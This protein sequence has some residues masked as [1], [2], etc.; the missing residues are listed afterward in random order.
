MNRRDVNVRR[1]DYFAGDY[2]DHVSAILDRCV[3]DAIGPETRMLIKPNLL[4]PAKPETAVLTHPSLVR[5]VCRYVLDAG[6]TPLVADSPATGSFDRLLRIGGYQNALT[7]LTVDIRPFADSVPVDIGAP[8]GTIDLTRDAVES[9]VVINLAKLKT[10][11]QMRLTLA[12]KNLFG[13]VVGMRKP[14]WHMRAGVDIDQFARLLVQIHYAI[15][16]AVSMIDGILAMEG[17]GPG[18]GGTPRHLGLLIGGTDAAAVDAVISSAIGLP[19]E[20]LPTHRAAVTLARFPGEPI[21]H[22]EIPPVKSFRLPESGRVIFGPRPIRHMVR[23]WVLHRPVVE[24]DRCRSCGE[25]WT[26]CPAAAVRESETAVDFDYDTCIRCYCCV[27]VCPHG[28]LTARQPA[29]GRILD[30]VR[31]AA[32]RL[33]RRV[34]PH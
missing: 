32:V 16:P 10:H 15:A 17:D 26:Y 21:L 20:E 8:F 5:E 2:H 27:E 29:A 14:E 24:P 19:P 23:Q 1:T 6:G 7:D 3:G 4:L 33:R 12:V 28:A 22:G 9:D 34:T 31:G 11:S 13:C 18:K 25:C 30:R